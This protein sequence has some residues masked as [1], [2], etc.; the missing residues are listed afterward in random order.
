MPQEPAEKPQPPATASCW[1][2]VG[3]LVLV[4]VLLAIAIPISRSLVGD[5]IRR[6]EKGA[7]AAAELYIDKESAPGSEF[8][9][10]VGELVSTH[11]VKIGTEKGPPAKV[12]V[13]FDLEGRESNG[14]ATLA[15]VERGG[16]F[17]VVD[18]AV[19][20]K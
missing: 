6:A 10:A 13:T 19:L 17:E 12:F 11:V 4:V 16:R 8:H 18:S 2:P 20:R 3:V 5:P 1:V 14:V 15:L 9:R 7:V